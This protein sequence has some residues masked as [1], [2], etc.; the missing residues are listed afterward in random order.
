MCEV[1]RAPVDSVPPIDRPEG[2]KEGEPDLHG[3]FFRQ[4]PH[5]SKHHSGG[6]TP[7]DDM[8]RYFDVCLVLHAEHSFNA[9]TFTA[10]QIASSRAHLYAAVAGAIGSLSGELHG[11]ANVRVMEMLMKIGSV[12]QVESYVDQELEAGRVIF[13]LGHAVYQ[14][15]DPRAHILAPMSKTMG[16]RIGQPQ[17]Y[18]ISKALEKA[19]KT[20]F[21][22]RKGIVIAVASAPSKSLGSK[23]DEIIPIPESNGYLT[24]ILLV[25]PLQLLAYHVA[26][27]KGTDVDQPRNLA[28]SVTV[29]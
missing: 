17:W 20:A 22:A 24:T 9:S 23:V 14:V 26:V 21:K 4:P 25:A 10:R 13:G 27:M 29:E 3:E 11:G 6:E 15:D 16:K 1:P 28:K 5:Q 18:E 8:A 2:D 7:D 19:G 12:D